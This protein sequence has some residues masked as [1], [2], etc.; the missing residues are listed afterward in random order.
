MQ[1]LIK[2]GDLRVFKD[3]FFQT[4]KTLE[5]LIIWIDIFRVNFSSLFSDF[6]VKL[7]NAWRFLSSFSVFFF[8]DICICQFFS[9]VTF[10]VFYRCIG[11]LL[12]FDNEIFCSSYSVVFFFT[13]GK[14]F[15][16]VSVK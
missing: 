4:W 10:H 12:T 8:S 7:I 3:I 16:P 6:N 9:S 11:E 14:T 13:L 5:S 15:M 1:L 2:K